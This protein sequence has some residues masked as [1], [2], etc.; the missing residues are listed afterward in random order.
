MRRERLFERFGGPRSAVVLGLTNA[1]LGFV[2]SEWMQLSGCLVLDYGC[3]VMPYS[4]AFELANA[5]VVG[6]DIG[7]NPHADVRIAGN[8][9]LPVEACAFDY[10][11]SFQV[12]EHVIIPQDYLREAF[13]TLKSGGT[14]FL[15]THGVWP[16]HPTPG[17]YH[18]WT[19][20]GLCAEVEH[21]GFRVQSVG[22]VLNGYSALLQALVMTAE[23]RGVLKGVG[24]LVH[25]LTHLFIVLL[26]WR[27][28]D[29]A[30]IPAVICISGGK[31]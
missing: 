5:K 18:R 21:A 9:P 27:G 3:G 22:Q 12:L 4:M 19:V 20:P 7:E 31:A 25:L 30:E 8:G 29:R 16:Y 11:V 24:S 1:V 15:T 17:D 14:L 26:E 13:R 23:Y 6:V 2:V 10:V 28:R